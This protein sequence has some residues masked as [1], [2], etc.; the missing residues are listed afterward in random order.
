MK[1]QHTIGKIWVNSEKSAIVHAEDGRIACQPNH[2]QRWA[3]PE[4]AR[5]MVACWN[6]CDGIDT[7]HLETAPPLQKLGEHVQQVVD[8]RDALKTR[9]D[10]M[11]T[12]R[13]NLAR[14][15]E[16]LEFDRAKIRQPTDAEIQRDALLVALK[17][18]M[19]NVSDTDVTINVARSAIAKATGV[20]S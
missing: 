6:K 12:E 7:E 15:V 10:I 2:M 13:D 17:T 4:N 14:R 19:L 18:I 16:A 8:Q 11:T 3:W 9:L 5:R 20:K 1:A